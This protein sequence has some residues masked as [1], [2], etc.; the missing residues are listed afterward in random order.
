MRRCR[1]N[2][3]D[4]PCDTHGFCLPADKGILKNIILQEER[5]LK[6][7]STKQKN[8]PYNKI[9]DFTDLKDMIYKNAVEF[10]DEK[11]IWYERGG[12]YITIPFKKF[13][14]DIDA[15][16]AYF[17]SLGLKGD[18]KIA[19]VGENSY[20]WVLTYFAAVMGANMIVPLD[21][22]LSPSELSVLIKSGEC[23]AVVYSKTKAA[24][25][26]LIEDM[27]I[28]TLCIDEFEKVIREG[29]E[30]IEAGDDEFI[31]KPMDIDKTC[32]IIFTSGTTGNPKG[33]MLSQRNLLRDA[34]H[35]LE[36]LKIPFGTVAV[37]PFNHTFGFMAGI[38]CQVWVGSPVFINSSLKTIL[39]DIQYA[40]PGHISVVPLFLES[41]HK[42]IWKN[43]QKQGKAGL[44]KKL[45]KVSDGARKI[46]IDA[47]RLLF[48]SVL[49]A[50]GGNLS[51][52][53]CGGAPIDDEL[54]K[55]FEALGIT[56]I[57]GYGI[58]ECS[59]IVA[60]NRACWVKYGTVG[61]PIPSVHIHIDNPNE[62][63]EGEICVKGDIVMQGYYNAPEATA[64]VL[65][66]GWFH[67]GDIGSV[68]KDG[69]LS[70][71]GRKKNLILLD[72]GKNVYPEELETLVGRVENVTE[73]LVYAEEDMITAE[74]YAENSDAK[75][76]I[77]ADIQALNKTI[78]G[79]KQI[80]K[81]KFRSVEFEKTTTKKIKRSYK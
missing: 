69:F 12:S 54:M 64:E 42:N 41:F 65:K 32:A 26:P 43:A 14:E 58:T 63:G 59:P 25:L 16:G 8:A 2:C 17:Y 56:V 5:L 77:K 30:K 44:L 34:R 68:D 70:I 81:I 53:I 66:D 19:V 7:M 55:S 18:K 13:R 10:A 79:Y 33:V 38:L 28:K 20:E 51:M 27:D 72:N 31:K 60:T 46:G 36:N 3:V 4:I 35:S 71:T 21:K 73:V 11:A 76:Q 80:R 57:N 48:K 39:R 61:L 29:N 15:L 37:L 24:V 49:D 6:I 9:K 52:L 40:K 22:E 74:I 78:A 1:Q 23:D 62:N 45:M 50:F 75:E 67:T 47:R